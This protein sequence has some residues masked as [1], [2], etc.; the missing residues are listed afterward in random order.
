MK[1]RIISMVNVIYQDIE[2]ESLFNSGKST[3]FKDV[4]NKKMFMQG[5]CSFITLLHV[6]NNVVELKYY[7]YLHYKHN[8]TFSTVTV[9]CPGLC[10]DLVFSEEEQGQ[11]VT[12]YQLII[13]KDYG[14]ERSI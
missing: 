7:E 11:K 9:E 4:M 13:N 12:I 14:K 10:G 8:S 5:L 3:A 1:D 2:L 6:V